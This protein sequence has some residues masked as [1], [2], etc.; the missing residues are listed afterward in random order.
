MPEIKPDAELALKLTPGGKP[1][2]AKLVG[3]LLPVIW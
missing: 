3:L 1:L 2:A